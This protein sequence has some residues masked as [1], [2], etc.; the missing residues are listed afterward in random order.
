M[1]DKLLYLL[2]VTCIIASA[3]GVY[4]EL[5]RCSGADCLIYRANFAG[6]TEVTSKATRDC[7]WHA[8]N[9]RRADEAILHGTVIAYKIQWFNGAWSDWFVPGQN[10]VDWKFNRSAR[11]CSVPVYANSLRRVW[12]YFYDHTHKYI[13]CKETLTKKVTHM[14]S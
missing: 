8:N 3:T 10:D 9:N 14:F 5:N 7:R 4:T 1:A 13:I 11:K 12:S 2:G 6:C